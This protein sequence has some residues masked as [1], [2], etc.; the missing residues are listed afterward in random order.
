M[1]QRSKVRF[2]YLPYSMINDLEKRAL[3][4]FSSLTSKKLKV[5]TTVEY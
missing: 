3:Y 4:K 2:G 1:Q 5:K